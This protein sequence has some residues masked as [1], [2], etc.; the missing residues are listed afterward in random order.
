MLNDIQRR[1]GNTPGPSGAAII[2]DVPKIVCESNY[3]SIIVRSECHKAVGLHDAYA[4]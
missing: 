3:S 1:P 4:Q 2:T